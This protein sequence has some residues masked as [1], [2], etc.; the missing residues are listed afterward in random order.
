MRLI[1]NADDF[2][3]SEET[4]RATIECFERGALTSAT[5]MAGMPATQLAL[6]YAR[7]RP[8]FSFG[9]HLTFVTDGVERPLAD[10]ATIPDLLGADGRFLPTGTVRKRA[11]LHRLPVPQLEREL[12]AQI[13]F[14]RD[15]GVPVSHVDSHR[16][17]HKLAPFREALRGVLPRFD[18]RRVRNVQDVF[19]RVPLKSATYWL[20]PVW[21][22]Q[23]MRRFA[24][25][26]HFYMPT[27]THDTAWSGLLL[28]R[29]RSLRGTLEVGVH[30]GY[31][32]YRDPERRSL[33]ELA[34]GA[35]AGGHRLIS[36]NELERAP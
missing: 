23:L 32:D 8:E 27:T 22:R 20:G 11:L 6:D 10:P 13:A 25:T 15:H 9:V 19:L 26:E 34:R 36:W 7:G 35:S 3:V 30:P 33:E 31:A 17:V 28:A 21:R 12:E 29:L 16:H 4:V 1:L 5:I 14:V 2:G 18:I 24:T